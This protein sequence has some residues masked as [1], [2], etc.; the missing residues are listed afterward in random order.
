MAG[1]SQR[2]LCDRR[3][4]P[5]DGLSVRSFLNGHGRD[6]ELAIEI[7]LPISLSCGR[8]SIAWYAWWDGAS[9]G[10]T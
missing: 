7:F 2:V 1:S 9:R 3:G 4:V 5:S 10:P 8:V 6:R